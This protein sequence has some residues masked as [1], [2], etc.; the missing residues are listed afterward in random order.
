MGT[1]PTD[2]SATLQTSGL[3]QELTGEGMI[4]VH[5]SPDPYGNRRKLQNELEDP[6]FVGLAGA[7]QPRQPIHAKPEI[8]SQKQYLHKFEDLKI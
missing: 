3:N 8:F 1:H 5:G 7:S 2:T 4:S 6:L